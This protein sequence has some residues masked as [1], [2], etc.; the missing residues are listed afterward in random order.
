MQDSADLYDESV[1]STMESAQ[2]SWLN[3]NPTHQN[4]LKQQS[5]EDD[6]EAQSESQLEKE[7]LKQCGSMERGD[8]SFKQCKL[9]GEAP[10][11][12]KLS[13]SLERKDDSLI[14]SEL[15]DEAFS[16]LSGSMER[17][18]DSLKLED[19]TRPD[20]KQSSSLESDDYL[21]QGN[22]EAGQSTARKRS[23]SSLDSVPSKHIKTIT[24][25]DEKGKH[26]TG[27]DVH[28]LVCDVLSSFLDNL[29]TSI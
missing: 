21:K 20:N 2:E 7:A 15:E 5:N 6:T 12:D 11:N 22:L 3:S 27:K 9:E 19:G 23:H 17:E 14:Q 1:S 4:V 18:D 26:F 16:K 10:S 8:A 13:G 24:P 28:R 25:F 29:F